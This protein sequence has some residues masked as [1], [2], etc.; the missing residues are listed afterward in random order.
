MHAHGK[1]GQELISGVQEGDVFVWVDFLQIRR[2][3]YNHFF[4]NRQPMRERSTDEFR[5]H[6]LQQLEHCERLRAGL[7]HL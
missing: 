4:S 1:T 5:A 7:V 6:P 3:L 2:E